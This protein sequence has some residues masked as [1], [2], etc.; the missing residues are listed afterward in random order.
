MK[1]MRLKGAALVASMVNFLV[2]ERS[3]QHRI[4]I[5][6]TRGP[7]RTRNPCKD[8]AGLLGAIGNVCIDDQKQPPQGKRGWRVILNLFGGPCQSYADLNF[9]QIFCMILIANQDEFLLELI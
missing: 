2:F 8:R 5:K 6:V 1:A 3:R 7:K 9:Y 4:V